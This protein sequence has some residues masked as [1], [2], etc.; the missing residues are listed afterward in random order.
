MRKIAPLLLLLTIMIMSNSCD[1]SPQ[2][3]KIEP[4]YSFL[5][6]AYTDS[7]VQGIGLLTFNPE[8]NTLQTQILAAGVSNPSFVISN[9]AQ[10]LVFAVEEIGG[11]N[12]GKVKS[13]NFDRQNNTLELLDSKDTFGDHPCYLSLDA[14]EDILVVGNY[15][16]GNFSAY[17][18][19]DGMLTHV[20]TYEHEGQSINPAR[21]EKAHVHSTVFHPNGK[22]LLV[23]DLGTDKIHLYDFNPSYAVPFNNSD[24]G[25]LEVSPGAGPRHLAIHPSGSPVYLIHEMTA[26]L[27]VYS[28][29][30]GQMTQMQVLPLTGA[31]FKGNVGAA[32]VRISPDAKFVYASNRGDANEITVYETG[33]G[34]ELTFVERINTGGETPRNFVITSDGKFLLAA[35]QGSGTIVVFERNLKTGKLSKTGAETEF[36]K[37]VYLF[38]LD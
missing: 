27:G 1:E 24:P 19:K 23:G 33:K 26:E 35:N 38:G 21:Q 11:E 8:N 20:Q 30:T 14:K 2:E 3:E 9:K 5:L 17:R 34:G 32:E 36:N 22:Q 28:Y 13:F 12:G 7:E 10:T 18:V 31:E 16:G 4:V 25:Y 15:S 6:G 29:D 37:P